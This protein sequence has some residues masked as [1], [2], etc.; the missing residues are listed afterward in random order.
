MLKIIVIDGIF[1]H[2]WPFLIEIRPFGVFEAKNGCDRVISGHL[3]VKKV[4]SRSWKLFLR[5]AYLSQEE[6]KSP[7]L[8]IR[9]LPIADLKFL[10]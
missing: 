3:R 8:I 6:I 1:I 2:F 9:Y 4:I 5:V 7:K 10:W